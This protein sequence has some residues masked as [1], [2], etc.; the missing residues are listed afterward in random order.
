[1]NRNKLT[2]SQMSYLKNKLINAVDAER[3]RRMDEH[4]AKVTQQ[5]PIV[6]SLT[7][8]QSVVPMTTAYGVKRPATVDAAYKVC[9]EWNRE[10]LKEADRFYAEE[11]AAKKALEASCA[12]L[13]AEGNAVYEALLFSDAKGALMAVNDFITKITKRTK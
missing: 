11:N 1:M 13:S 5:G 8:L 4:Y 9:V 10:C 6:T 12:A 2:A 3:H 7:S